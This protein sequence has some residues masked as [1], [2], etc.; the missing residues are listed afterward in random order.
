MFVIL[1]EQGS[2]HLRQLHMFGKYPESWTSSHICLVV[3]S[4]QP[5]LSLHFLWEAYIRLLESRGE[6]RGDWLA[7]LQLC[8]TSL[9]WLIFHLSVIGPKKKIWHFP[10]LSWFM[11]KEHLGQ[12]L[13]IISLEM[14]HLD[15]KQVC[16]FFAAG[17]SLVLCSLLHFFQLWFCWIGWVSSAEPLHSPAWSS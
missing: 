13:A 8:F 16:F 1:E 17:F 9:M 2:L 15:R 11:L 6:E 10:P 4:P 12:G 5:M 7:S 14:W 3:F